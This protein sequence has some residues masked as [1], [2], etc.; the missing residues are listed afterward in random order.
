MTAILNDSRL[1]DGKKKARL[2]GYAESMTSR[3]LNI[4]DIDGAMNRC[5]MQSTLSVYVINNSK[6]HKSDCER[7]FKKSQA[8]L[9]WDN[10][11]CEHIDYNLSDLNHCALIS[12]DNCGVVYVMFMDIDAPVMADR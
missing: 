4:T 11:N 12:D 5:L 8:T 1:L 10:A 9:A 7:T 3:R 6:N 2:M